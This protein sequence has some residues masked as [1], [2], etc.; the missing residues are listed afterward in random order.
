MCLMSLI[1][2]YFLTLKVKEFNF[3]KEIGG[4]TSQVAPVA[5]ALLQ[6]GCNYKVFTKHPL[7]STKFFE[8]LRIII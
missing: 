4:L 7:L 8:D 5:A 6:F 3:R 2:K 1:G